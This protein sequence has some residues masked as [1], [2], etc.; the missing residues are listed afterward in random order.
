[1]FLQ[2]GR[3]VS[4]ESFRREREKREREGRRPRV[5]PYLALT[6]SAAPTSP[7]RGVELTDRE[8][9]H[10]RRMLQHL[11]DEAAAPEPDVRW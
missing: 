6:T 7:F 3:V 8:V 10:R 9:G 4:F 1:M 11:S 2:P 5:L